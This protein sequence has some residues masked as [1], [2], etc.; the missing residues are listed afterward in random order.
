YAVAK[1]ARRLRF[2]DER[3]A[4]MEAIIAARAKEHKKAP[5]G[6]TGLLVKR[7]RS[8]GHGENTLTVEEYEVDVGLLRQIRELEKQVGQQFEQWVEKHEMAGKGGTS[9]MPTLEQMV[10]ALRAGERQHAL[11]NGASDP[12]PQFLE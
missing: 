10:A 6:K 5:G 4:K 3:Y 8:I 9:L 12:A 7:L 2:M 1:L 11:T